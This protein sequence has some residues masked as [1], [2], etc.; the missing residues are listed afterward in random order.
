M[1]REESR[2]VSQSEMARTGGN[3]S[4]GRRKE[5]ECNHLRPDC[6]VVPRVSG[7]MSLEPYRTKWNQFDGAYRLPGQARCEARCLRIGQAPQRT[8]KAWMPHRRPDGSAPW[9]RCPPCPRLLMARCIA[10]RRAPSHDAVLS[11]Q[12]DRIRSEHALVYRG[13]R[14]RR[15]EGGEGAARRTGLIVVPVKAATANDRFGQNQLTH[16][17]QSASVIQLAVPKTANC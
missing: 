11:G 8:R 4:A 6:S 10:M 14:H 9:R 13:V 17:Q 16:M 1:G 12:I 3:G 2:W 7:L 5:S 15:S